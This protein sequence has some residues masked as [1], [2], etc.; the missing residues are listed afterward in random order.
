MA[1]FNGRYEIN[2]PAESQVTFYKRD[3]DTPLSVVTVD[4]NQRTR[5]S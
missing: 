4:D 1:M 2:K 5:D 3:N